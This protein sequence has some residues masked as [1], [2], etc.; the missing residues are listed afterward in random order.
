MSPCH[1]SEYCKNETGVL[2]PTSLLLSGVEG[3][4]S[5]RNGRQRRTAFVSER[6]CRCFL[7]SLA[8]GVSTVHFDRSF[9][10][11]Q[12]YSSAHACLVHPYA[13]TPKSKTR[14]PIRDE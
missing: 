5:S 11:W 9:I 12:M 7:S 10:F 1:S 3:R 4:A 14:I 2:R 8:Q 6:E 13:K